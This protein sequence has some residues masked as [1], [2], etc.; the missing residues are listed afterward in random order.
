MQDNNVPN[1]EHVQRLAE[2]AR[3]KFDKLQTYLKLQSRRNYFLLEYLGEP[4]L[5]NHPT[6]C[7]HCDNCKNLAEDKTSLLTIEKV[8]V[9]KPPDP[10]NQSTVKRLTGLRDAYARKHKIPAN[11]VMSSTTISNIANA[12]P[13]TEQELRAI[14]VSDIAI[15]YLGRTVLKIIEEQRLI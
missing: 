3:V 11:R 14:G 4:G 5:S 12:S 7:T 6:Q 2:A 8:N 15:K 1:F 10:T 9:A 13:S